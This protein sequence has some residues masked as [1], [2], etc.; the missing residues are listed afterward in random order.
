MNT[1]N[2]VGLII[3]LLSLA[4]A[5]MQGMKSKRLNDYFRL[6]AW[7]LYEESSEVLARIQDIEKDFDSDHFDDKVI[8]KKIVET[9]CYG[10]QLLKDT[11]K[12]I[13]KTEKRFDKSVI[14]KW[15]EEKRIP[16]E[17]HIRGFEH[18]IR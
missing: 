3:G 1:L 17:S 10:T 6:E 11:I 2:I 8:R 5:I 13:K 4:Y 15:F 9:N 7:L 16:N 18:L 14:N 12:N